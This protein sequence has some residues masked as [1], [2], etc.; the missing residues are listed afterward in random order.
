MLEPQRKDTAL[1]PVLVLLVNEGL[2]DV[3]ASGRLQQERHQGAVPWGSAQAC[4]YSRGM[5]LRLMVV[6]A[7]VRGAPSEVAAA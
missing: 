5:Q 6:V 4:V 7:R 3:T 1:V 2:G